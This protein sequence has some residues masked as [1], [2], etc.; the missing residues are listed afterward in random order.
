MSKFSIDV[1]VPIPVTMRTVRASSRR[2]E[3]VEKICPHMT[4]VAK[5]NFRKESWLR[6]YHPGKCVLLGRKG[7]T[8]NYYP[9]F[10]CDGPCFF[11]Y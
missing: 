7:F 10:Q 1:A 4:L 3:M 8:R 5:T 9:T 2:M 11:L 6:N